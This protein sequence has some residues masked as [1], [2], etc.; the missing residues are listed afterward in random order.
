MRTAEDSTRK[1]DVTAWDGFDTLH[2]LAGVP[3]TRT[4]LNLTGVSLVADPN[5]DSAKPRLVPKS[6]IGDLRASAIPT[7][8]GLEALAV[9]ARAASEINF[10]GT[11]LALTAFVSS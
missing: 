8:E 10:V 9:E 2:I 4:L 3:S 6:E 5:D 1:S 7:V 11:V